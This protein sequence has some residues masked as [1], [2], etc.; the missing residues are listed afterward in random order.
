MVGGRKGASAEEQLRS[1]LEALD[2]FL[3]G[4]PQGF[5][6]PLMPE[7]SFTSSQVRDF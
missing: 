2:S 5:F 7:E 6:D 4:V 3:T 1:I